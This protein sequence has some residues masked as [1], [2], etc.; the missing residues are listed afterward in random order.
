MAGSVQSGV[1]GWLDR[2]RFDVIGAIF[3]LV[4]AVAMLPLRFVVSNLYV[5]GIPVAIGIASGLYLLS[6]RSEGYGTFPT[7]PLWAG[8]ALPSATMLGMSLLVAIGFL[9]NGRSPIF[10]SLATLVAIALF[11][12]ILFVD[13]RDYAPMLLLAQLLAFAFVIRFV[14]LRTMPGY[15]GIDI[16]SHIPSFTAAILE[17][18][19]LSPIADNK[20]FAS[21]LFHLLIVATSLLADLS[22]RSAAHFSVG[23]AMVLAIP[24]VYLAARLFVSARWSL[25]AASVYAISGYTVEWGIHLI[26]TTLGLVFFLA[27]LYLLCRLLYVDTGLHTFTLLLVLSVATILTHQISSF[28][29]LVVTG[30]G[31]IA[32]LALQFD[33]LAPRREL[34]QVRSNAQDSAN[35]TGLLAFDLGFITFMWSL[36]PHYGSTFLEIMFSFFY[37]TI[38]ETEG[39]IDPASGRVDPDAPPLETPL[40]AEVVNYVD[41]IAFLVPFFL[42]VAG[43]LFVLRRRNVSHATFMCASAVVIMCVFVFAFPIAGVRTFVPSRWYAFMLAPMAVLGAI[44]VAHLSRNL[45]PA[46]VLSVLLVL[47]L[48]LPAV[49]FAGSDGTIDRPA[50]EEVQTRYS[51]TAGELSAVET[52]DEIIGATDEEDGRIFTDHP[53]H[54]VFTRTDTVRASA[55]QQG[56]TTM[57]YE[58]IVH[59]EYLADGAAFT[60]DEWERAVTDDVSAAELCGPDR[61]YA[62]DNG[63]VTMCVATWDTDAAA[64]EVGFEEEEGGELEDDGEV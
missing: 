60:Q 33:L 32:H 37:T 13:E 27:I 16:W 19:S 35:L 39:I 23:L 25:L 48:V 18:E 29:V 4:L 12:Q 40:V 44:G 38:S 20:Y 62:Y 49:A 1:Y 10:Y 3:G 47:T 7:L 61:H 6:V 50:F 42:T 17:A 56:E 28:I 30:A 8:R 2:Q 52:G 9:Q 41:A 34:S 14:A 55:A 64:E 63:E 57:A 31:L 21:P 24:F 11:A 22:I 36:T 15:V 5:L 26:P 43:C 54:T 46:G 53:Y 45:H 51:Y 59:R 58:V